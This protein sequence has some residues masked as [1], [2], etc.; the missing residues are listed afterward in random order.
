[1][2]RFFVLMPLLGVAAFL[3]F[4]APVFN[5]S[6]GNDEYKTRAQEAAQ[7]FMSQLQGVLMAELREGGPVQALSVCAD[8]AQALTRSAADE[9]GVSIKRVSDRVRNTENRPDEYEKKI[10]E[11]FAQMHREG[12]EPPFIHTGERTIDGQ[13][14][15]WYIQSIHLQAQCIGCHGDEAG[16]AENVRTLLREKYPGDKATGYK[17]G[18]FRGAIRVSFPVSTHEE[19]DL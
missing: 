8:T 3:L 7:S 14:E 1:M 17:P 10:L 4:S 18:D 9:L 6:G 11:K 12:Q 16:I 2:K 13:N 15:F 5:D 19:E